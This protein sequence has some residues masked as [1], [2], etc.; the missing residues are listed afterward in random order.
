M[1]LVPIKP[2]GLGILPAALS[3][4]INS[5]SYRSSGGWGRLGFFVVFV[6]WLPVLTDILKILS[7]ERLYLAQG[8][9][10]L[11]WNLEVS[12]LLSILSQGVTW[13]GPPGSS[14]SPSTPPSCMSR[15][16][17]GWPLIAQ[18]PFCSTRQVR[19]GWEQLGVDGASGGRRVDRSKPGGSRPAAWKCLWPQE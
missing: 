11:M 7:E 2:S 12:P 15:K 19:E 9:I 5:S 1:Q 4:L 3:N 10:K 13:R 6:F 8:W 16:V 14:V 18:A 17:M